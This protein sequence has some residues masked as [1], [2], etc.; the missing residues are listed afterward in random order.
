[1]W[2]IWI[3]S[4]QFIAL[5]SESLIQSFQFRALNPEL[6]IYSFQFRASDSAI[7]PLGET[8]GSTGSEGW[9]E[10]HF[11]FCLDFRADRL[12]ALS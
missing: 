4:F 6:P 3:V 7:S 5:D 2:L 12:E 11:L 8:T 10:R 1:M 9:S